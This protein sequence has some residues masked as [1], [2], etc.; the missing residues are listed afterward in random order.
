MNFMEWTSQREQQVSKVDSAIIFLHH[1]GIHPDRMNVQQ[2]ADYLEAEE[3]IPSGIEPIRFAA[4]VKSRSGEGF[5][6]SQD[7]QANWNA[8]GD[9]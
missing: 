5:D 8:R 3:R 2:L 4:M 1:L 9:L 6:P 7:I